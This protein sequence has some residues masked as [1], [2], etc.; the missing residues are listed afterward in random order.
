MVKT[1]QVQ[2]KDPEDVAFVPGRQL[3]LRV[4]GSRP[5]QRLRFG[6]GLGDN[7]VDVLLHGELAIKPSTKQ[8]EARP[9]ARPPIND[10]EFLFAW[11]EHDTVGRTPCVYLRLLRLQVRHDIGVRHTEVQVVCK[12]GLLGVGGVLDAAYIGREH[13]PERRT[14]YGALKDGVADREWTG[15]DT[16]HNDDTLPRLQEGGQEAEHGVTHTCASTLCEE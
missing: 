10:A 14:Q 9:R 3:A 4:V 7:L 6:S 13:I 11:I 12:L 8:P 5:K 2:L 16:I 15:R 1:S